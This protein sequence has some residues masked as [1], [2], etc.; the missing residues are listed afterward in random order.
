VLS[1]LKPYQI[2]S[3]KRIDGMDRDETCEH[4]R[5]KVVLIAR[6]VFLR[7]GGHETVTVDDLAACG[8]LGL[9]EAFERFDPARGVHFA[10]YAEYRIRGAM[11]DALRSE[12]AFSRRRRNMAKRVQ[13]AAL[14]VQHREGREAEP[15]EVAD[16]LGITLEEYWDVVDRVKPVHLSS[17]DQPVGEGED[18]GVPLIERLMEEG[19]PTVDRDLFMEQVRAHLKN[20][21]AELPERERQCVLLYYG[22]DMTQAEIAAVYGVTVPRISQIL[23]AAR[24]RLRKKLLKVLDMDDINALV[25]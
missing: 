9:I 16:E 11:F 6:R 5:W 25:S 22:K 15:Q 3:R 20:A 4:Y 12:D 7:Q 17:L 13:H 2:A 18:D 23:T 1:T 19:E 14:R 24:E 8:A 10:A 21:V